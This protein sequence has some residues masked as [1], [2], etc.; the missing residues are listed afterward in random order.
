MAQLA[1]VGVVLVSPP[2]LLRE[3]N[4][5]TP[6]L[7]RVIASYGRR[8]PPPSPFACLSIRGTGGAGRVL[9][10]PRQR[11]IL[12]PRAYPTLAFLSHSRFFFFLFF[13]SFSVV[14]LAMRKRADGIIDLTRESLRRSS[15]AEPRNFLECSQLLVKA[16]P[17]AQVTRLARV[18]GRG[19]PPI[20][21]HS[22]TFPPLHRR[23]CFSQGGSGGADACPSYLVLLRHAPTP[24]TYLDN[25]WHYLF[26]LLPG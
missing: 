19:S 2:A 1:N 25:M 21:P 13:S 26:Y 16:Q 4:E 15:A 12:V 7:K 10:H 11:F 18:G 17:G 3:G 23:C 9:P 14:N 20:A 6:T 24:R 5:L 22:Y 8:H